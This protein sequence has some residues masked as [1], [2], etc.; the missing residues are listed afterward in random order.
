MQSILVNRLGQFFANFRQA[1]SIQGILGSL[2]FQVCLRQSRK[3]KLL[4]SSM[5]EDQTAVEEV[6]DDMMEARY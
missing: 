4:A 1:L 5:R 2:N 6:T 3:G